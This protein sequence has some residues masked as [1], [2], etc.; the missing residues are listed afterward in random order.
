MLP[1]SEAGR[2]IIFMALNYKLSHK[3]HV[4]AGGVVLV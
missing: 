3:F 1:A 2:V 4:G